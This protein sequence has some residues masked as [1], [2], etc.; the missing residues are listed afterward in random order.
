MRKGIC[1]GCLPGTLS[2]AER[3]KLARD[4]GFDGV[5]LPG[6]DTEE[7]T[8]R[9][10]E[11]ADQAGVG[12]PSIMGHL[13][14]QYPLSSPDP[15]VRKRCADG[16]A[17]SLHHAARIG[18]DTVLCVPAVVTP[19]VCYEEA[20]ER[21]QE[22]IR[23]LAAV[24]EAC[25]VNLA[26]ENVWNKFLL[27]PVEFRNYVDEIDSPYVK[28]YFDCGNIC[29]YGFP[30]QWIRT[31]GADRIAKMHIKGFTGYPDV[32]FP[33]TLMSD[34]PWAECRKAWLAVGYDDYLTVEIGARG[35]DPVE[36]IHDYSRELDRIL[37]GEV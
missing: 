13:H 8:L 2:E 36:S 34:V 17:A 15:D 22:E 9:L 27:S 12:T 23:N 4:A 11:L 28:A 7:E 31:L 6:T 35:D 14:W 10:K 1:F 30:Q 21:S 37:A 16:F 25:R 3:F 24:A 18:A 32:G 26:I 33:Q 5:E 19:E 29:L 20:Y